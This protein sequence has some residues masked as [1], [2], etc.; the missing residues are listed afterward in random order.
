VAGPSSRALDALAAA[1]EL[2]AILAPLVDRALIAKRRRAMNDR[3][4]ERLRAVLPLGEV[5]LPYL[6]APDF[7]VEPLEELS[8]RLEAQLSQIALAG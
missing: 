6:F 1:P 2:P 3:Y 4:L 7:G 8:K 5:Q